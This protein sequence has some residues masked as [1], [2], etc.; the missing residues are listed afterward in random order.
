MSKS[1][2][3]LLDDDEDLLESLE[4]F[5]QEYAHVQSFLDSEKAWAALQR[6][7]PSKLACIISDVRMPRLS[8]LDLLLRIRTMPL[9]I[10]L[11]LMTGHGDIAMAVE[12]IKKGAF[13]FV[14]KPFSPQDL[15]QH[16]ESAWN[17]YAHQHTFFK[18]TERF[19]TLSKREREIFDLVAEGKMNKVIADDLGISVKTVEAHR[20]RMIEKLGIDSLADLV[21]FHVFLKKS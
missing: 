2:V 16:M 1:I 21:R 3:Y 7:P 17:M 11:I 19:A 4:W 20:G 18:L 9:P 8:G 14:E 12:A 15:V 6:H 13:Y 5:L 10:P